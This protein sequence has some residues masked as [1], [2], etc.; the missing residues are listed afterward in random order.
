[1]SC[2]GG[3]TRI[4]GEPP[5]ES[6]HQN[7]G[8]IGPKS[9]HMKKSDLAKRFFIARLEMERAKERERGAGA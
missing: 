4:S 7:V 9:N 8:N 5:S 3:P 1:M 2:N 6:W